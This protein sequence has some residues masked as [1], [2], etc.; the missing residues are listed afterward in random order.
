MISLNEALYHN[1]LCQPWDKNL[2]S[3]A[4]SLL[5]YRS[6]VVSGIESLLQNHAGRG[7]GVGEEIV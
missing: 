3:T 2:D 7:G 1:C 5:I 4:L 6:K